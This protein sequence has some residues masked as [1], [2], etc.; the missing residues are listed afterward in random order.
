MAGEV[1]L[2]GPATGATLYYTVMGSGNSIWSTS[3]GGGGFE[4]FAA[5][6]WADYAVTLTE[7][8]ATNVY[9]GNFPSSAPAGV[10]DIDARRQ[11]GASP[12][13]TDASVAG[14]EVEW[15]GNKRLPLS[16]LATSGQL[17]S[18]GP[19]R[20]TAGHAVSGFPVY[21]K[22][23]TDHVTPLTSGVVSGQISRNGGD[24]GPLQSGAF[25][26]IGQGWYKVNLTSGDL[27]AVTVAMLFTAN[28]IS[29]GA[30]DPV[31]MAFVL[32]RG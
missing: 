10:Y 29:G 17:A 1:K 18:V 24:F 26:E 13:T 25:S 15:A 12:A 6:N 4:A 16:D 19:V 21:L 14:G 9:K 27:N 23:A 2:R 8:G 3:G 22:S 20:L 5:A 7:Q 11:T 30:S 28:Q 31:P 32:Q